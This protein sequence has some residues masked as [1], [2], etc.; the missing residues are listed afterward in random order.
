M[1]HSYSV[2]APVVVS[3]EPKF[4]VIGQPQP[5]ILE[6]KEGLYKGAATNNEQEPERRD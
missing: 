5:L 6:N 4:P 2:L 3:F 1:G